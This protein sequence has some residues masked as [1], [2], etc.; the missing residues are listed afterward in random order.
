MFWSRVA[1][2][3]LSAKCIKWSA[4]MLEATL[5]LTLNSRASQDRVM[6]NNSILIYILLNSTLVGTGSSTE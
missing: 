4:R 3:P 1:D 2:V 5:G 6:Q